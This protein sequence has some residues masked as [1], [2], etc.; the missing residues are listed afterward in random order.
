[1]R[2]RYLGLVLAVLA[3]VLAPVATAGATQRVDSA[4]R[5]VPATGGGATLGREA[6]HDED[7]FVAPDTSAA[8]ARPFVLDAAASTPCSPVAD[9]GD[10][11]SSIA[12]SSAQSRGPPP[13]PFS[14]C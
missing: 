3:W 10:R 9:H 2:D 4:S 1:M 8:A 11:S 5:A 7:H 14:V 13:A 12:L 6:E